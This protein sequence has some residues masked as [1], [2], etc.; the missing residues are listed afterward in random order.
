M[1]S[2]AIVEYDDGGGKQLRYI[3]A[4]LSN[5]LCRN[6]IETHQ[7]LARRIHHVIADRHGVTVPKPTRETEKVGSQEDEEGV[8]PELRAV[9]APGTLVR[10]TRGRP[11]LLPTSRSIW[12]MICESHWP[13]RDPPRWRLR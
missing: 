9:V 12:M 10:R 3:V 8:L 13:P 6:S 5:V 11:S 1:N 4:L 7:A 2:T